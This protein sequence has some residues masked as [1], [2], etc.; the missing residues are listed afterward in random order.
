MSCLTRLST[1]Q[2]TLSCK[3]NGNPPPE[4]QWVHNARIIGN[5]SRSVYGDQR[6]VVL[7]GA[8]DQGG[9]G[10]AA[11]TMRWVNLTIRGVRPQD[12]G[13]FVCVAQSGGGVD[14]RNVTL[15][16]A[17]AFGGGGLLVGAGGS[18]AEAWPL[19]AGLVAGV[20][21]LLL[22][23]VLLFCCVARR[24]RDMQ[25]RDA[26]LVIGKK[27][28]PEGRSVSPSLHCHS[29]GPTVS[30]TTA[31]LLRR[32]PNGDVTHHVRADGSEQQKSLLT[33]VNPVQKPPRRYDHPSGLSS[34]SGQGGTEL[35]ELSE[36]NRN[37]LDDGSIYG[38][39]AKR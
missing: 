22:A 38:T 13:Q 23:T 2:V 4:V 28:P 27:P 30:M 17:R 35:S 24:R 6:F 8:A 37:L 11:S 32:S 16:V 9:A 12:R 39:V 33:M 31:F 29:P 34:L 21:L 5:N 18:M 36:L 7:E 19:I 10:L 15:K 26:A 20:V 14:E 25:R 1:F 3:V